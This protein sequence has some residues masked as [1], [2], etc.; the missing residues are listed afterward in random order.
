MWVV[1][2]EVVEFTLLCPKP[3]CTLSNISPYD[4]TR[5]VFDRLTLSRFFFVI[6]LITPAIASEPYREEAA[7]FTISIRSILAGLIILKSFCPPVSPLIRLPLI[8]IKM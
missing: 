3:I 4:P 7:P 8:R 1:L 5:V 6:I 2:S